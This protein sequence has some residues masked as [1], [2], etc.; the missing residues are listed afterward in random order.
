M[1]NKVTLGMTKNEVDAVMSVKPTAETNQY[2]YK[3]TFN[4]E[5]MD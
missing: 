3:N 4:Y 1:Y 2:A 5:D